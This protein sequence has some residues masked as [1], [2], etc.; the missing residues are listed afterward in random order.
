MIYASKRSQPS[1][2]GR[3]SRCTVP[4]SP[5]SQFPVVFQPDSDLPSNMGTNSSAACARSRGPVQTSVNPAA[6]SAISML[7]SVILLSPIGILLGCPTPGTV[8]CRASPGQAALGPAG[9][10]GYLSCSS[11]SWGR[12][13]IG[14]PGEGLKIRSRNR[15]HR[16]RRSK[17]R[18][19][20]FVRRICVLRRGSRH[21]GV[22]NYC[23]RGGLFMWS[24]SL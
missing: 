17:R 5:T 3:G 20:R 9:E 14:E 22:P 8:S 19:S 2:P 4:S 6:S 10:G 12:E 7:R 18:G 15:L 11:S 21:T 23:R 16:H 24:P 13:Q 1:S